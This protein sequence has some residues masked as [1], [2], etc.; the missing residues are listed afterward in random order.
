M[1]RPS[2]GQD[3]TSVDDVISI[4]GDTNWYSEDVTK[5]RHII[6]LITYGIF[7]TGYNYWAKTESGNWLLEKHLEYDYTGQD[8]KGKGFVYRLIIKKASDRL[9][10]KVQNI[11]KSNHQEYISVRKMKAN[12]NVV[13]YTKVILGTNHYYLGILE[14]DV[15]REPLRNFGRAV[16]RAKIHITK[17][18]MMEIIGN[19]YDILPMDTGNN[20]LPVGT[21]TPA[22]MRSDTNGMGHENTIIQENINSGQPVMITPAGMGGHIDVPTCTLLRNEPRPEVLE[23]LLDRGENISYGSHTSTDNNVQSVN[24]TKF[25]AMHPLWCCKHAFQKNKLCKYVICALCFK[26]GEQRR[27]NTND[28]NV[29]ATHAPNFLG[30]GHGNNNLIQ[31]T[32]NQY[33]SKNVHQ[34][35]P[36][37]CVVCQYT[38]VK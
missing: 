17:E 18:T 7:R 29:Q 35:I 28:T 26:P 16:T 31:F 5:H 36:Q 34:N 33:I 27:S 21:L 19:I 12:S 30:C 37:T 20:E 8:R 15:D 25:D 10:K 2:D 22:S 1:K 24:T 14:R 11:M 4:F 38:I 3:P 13:S 23:Q 9:A 32:D 6:Y